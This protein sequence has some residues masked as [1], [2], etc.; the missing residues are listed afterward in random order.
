MSSSGRGGASSAPSTTSA[1]RGRRNSKRRQLRAEAAG[2]D[3]HQPSSDDFPVYALVSAGV[4]QVQRRLPRNGLSDPLQVDL[5][6]GVR[7]DD[8][9]GG[10]IAGLITESDMDFVQHELAEAPCEVP[11]CHIPTPRIFTRMP[12]PRMDTRSIYTSS[13][14]RQLSVSVILTWVWIWATG[15]ARR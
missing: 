13:L 4:S 14:G 1:G 12:G 3:A 15:A 8:G 11:A 5:R 2:G 9:G 7:S 10:S 6:D